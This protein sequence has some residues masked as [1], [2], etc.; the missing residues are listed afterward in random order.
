MRRLRMVR[1]GDAAASLSAA[2]LFAHLWVAMVDLLGTSATATLLTR[3]ARRAQPRHRELQE[4]AISRVDAEFTYVVPDAF[5]RTQG[6]PPALLAL[7]RELQPLLAD[8]T[9]QVALNHLARVPELRSW[10]SDA[11]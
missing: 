9:G 10:V 6:P 7:V 2:A 1:P 11:A 3:A 8:S 4:L 5:V